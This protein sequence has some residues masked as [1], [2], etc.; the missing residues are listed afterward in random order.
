MMKRLSFKQK[1]LEITIHTIS[2]LLIFIFPIMLTEWGDK[3]DWARYWRGSIVPLCCFVMFYINYLCLVPKFLFRNNGVKFLLVNAVLIIL[4]TLG[5]HYVH[6]L[7]LNP[8]HPEFVPGFM[9]GPPPPHR[10]MFLGRQLVMMAFVVGLSTAIRVSIRW[11]YTEERLVETE[12]EKTE[13][14]LKNLKNQLNPH[15]LLNT[16]NNIYALIA[17]DSS[18]AQEAVQELSKML[19]YVLY[20]NQSGKVSLAK[21][22]DFINN[23]ISLMRIRLSESVKVS[24]HL[25]AGKEPILISPLIF[26]SLIENAF[27]HGVSPTEESFISISITGH[28]DGRVTCEIMNSNFPKNENDKSGNG[29]GLVQVRR[30]LDFAYPGRYEWNKGTSDNDSIYI[31]TLTIQTSE[32]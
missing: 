31:S 22:L 18:R 16:L 15:F 17:F 10:W 23:Y 27:K 2:W 19:R 8:P 7:F 32:L 1:R 14:E 29:I 30:R 9:P 13:A 4:I 5:I 21:E 28:S 6:V 3:V 11:R 12:R 20:D 25:D 26:I 24:V